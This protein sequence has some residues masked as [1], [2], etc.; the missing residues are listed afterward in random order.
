MILRPD[1]PASRRI[2]PP[3]E[4][5][6]PGGLGSFHFK[7]TEAKDRWRAVAICCRAGYSDR[8]NT[9]SSPIVC[10]VRDRQT[11]HAGSSRPEHPAEPGSFVSAGLDV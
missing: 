7:R 9:R 10:D 4:D 5:H 2:V 8:F 1:L 11:Q 6:E 3:G